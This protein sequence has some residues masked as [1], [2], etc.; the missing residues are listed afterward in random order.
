MSLT[1]Q[2]T[3][4]IA[5]ALYERF[6]DTDPKTVRFTDMHNGFVSWTVLTTIRKDRM[7]KYWKRSYW[8]G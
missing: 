8:S 2:D 1:W 5:E 7:K 6:P 4:E 3:R